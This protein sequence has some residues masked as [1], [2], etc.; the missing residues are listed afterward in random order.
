[1]WGWLARLFGVRGAGGGKAGGREPLCVEPGV[2][3]GISKAIPSLPP[4]D[5][6]P[7]EPPVAPPPDR[8]ASFPPLVSSEP[9]WSKTLPDKILFVDV[10]TTGIG[11]DDRIVSMATLLLKT[12]NL[13]NGKITASYMHGIFDPT[14]KSHP[15]A[16]LVH[17]YDDWTLRH[18][19]PFS[20]SASAFNTFISEADLLVAH[21]ADFDISFINREFSFSGIAPLSIPTY[22]TMKAYRAKGAGGSAAL[23]AICGRL[24]IKR[25]GETHGALEDAWLAM[26]V[27]LWLHECP[28]YTTPFSSV[29]DPGPVNF[30][31][32]PPRPEGKFPPRR[33]KRKIKITGT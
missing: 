4:A 19:E 29:Q 28:H 27:Y 3:I 13:K 15:K 22:C 12:E 32:P 25:V 20:G 24:G 26:Q 11:G 31:E 2:R 5:P 18:Q 30:R 16:E 10:E 23:A 8:P 21:N 14:K 7:P 33:R 9:K 6:S 17:G 1:M